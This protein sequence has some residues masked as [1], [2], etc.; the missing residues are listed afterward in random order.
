M[1][2]IWHEEVERNI[3]KGFKRGLVR[4]TNIVHRDAVLLVSKDTHYLEESIQ[5]YVDY[6]RL[7]GI[8]TTNCEYAF[9]Q[10][11]GFASMPKYTFSPY[12]RPA[13]N[14]NERNI[15]NMFKTEI[16]KAL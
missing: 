6:A 7:F 13:L 14:N 15:F 1:S 16:G 2:L 10:E 8:V 11:F 5:K 3:E 9:A 12:M 4:A